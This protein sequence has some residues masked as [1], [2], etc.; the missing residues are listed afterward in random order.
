[1]GVGV[2]Y[3]HIDESP[4]VNDEILKGLPLRVEGHARDF[5]RDAGELLDFVLKTERRDAVLRELA[6]GYL[7]RLVAGVGQQTD[8]E[9]RFVDIILD[10]LILVGQDLEYR[11]C[12]C[13][14][15]LVIHLTDLFSQRLHPILI[16][17]HPV[18]VVLA[19][20]GLVILLTFIELRYLPFESGH[21]L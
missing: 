19:P 4:V 2:F 6:L 15:G 3:A 5:L 16:L 18:Q 9:Q 10:H 21:G 1:M 20:R 12:L 8:A 11:G 17:P 7:A 14:H 13:L